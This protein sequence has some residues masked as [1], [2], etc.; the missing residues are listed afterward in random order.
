MSAAALTLLFFFILMLL[1]Y[2]AGRKEEALRHET[3]K[4]FFRA[5]ARRIWD[6]LVS[7]PDY[8]RRVRKRFSR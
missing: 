5:E 8:A 7:D 2:R 6:R 4:A 1:S 3:K